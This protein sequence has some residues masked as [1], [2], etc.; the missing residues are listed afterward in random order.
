MTSRPRPITRSVRRTGLR[1][2]F[3]LTEM[4]VVIGITSVLLFLLF[5]PLSRVLD[6]TSRAEAKV[7]GQDTVRAAMRRVTRDLSN[8][9]VI[10]PPRDVTVWGFDRWVN[11]KNRPRPDTGARPEPYVLRNGVIAFRLPKHRYFCRASELN[12]GTP[13]HYVTPQD[14]DSIAPGRDP[15]FDDAIALDTCPRH[16]AAKVDLKVQQPLE[17]DERVTAYFVGLKNPMLLDTTTRLPLYQNLLAF[18]AGSGN[19]LNTYVLYRVEFDPAAPQFA[20]FGA[21]NFFYDATP[22]R[23]PVSGLTKPFSQ[24]WLESSTAIIQDDASD[25]IRW[26]ENSSTGKFVPSSVVNFATTPF[27]NDSAQPN[28]AAGQ[29]QLSGFAAATDLPA[30]DYSTQYGNWVLTGAMPTGFAAEGDLAIPDALRVSNAVSAGIVQGPHIQVFGFAV[31]KAGGA[32]VQ[33]LVFDSETPAPRKR[34]VAFDPIRGVVS[35]SLPRRRNRPLD[36]AESGEE[37]RFPGQLASM[38]RD[39]F[40]ATIDLNGFLVQL[41]DDV[42]TAGL[43]G[44]NETDVNT[45]MPVAYGSARTRQQTIETASANLEDYTSVAPG[46][47]TVTLVDTSGAILRTEPLRRAGW[48]GLGRNDHPISQGDLQEDEY[49]I[50]YRSG[51]ITLSDRRPGIW[52]S[53]GPASLGFT[54]HLMVKYEFQTNRSNDIVKVSY[55]TREL[56]TV[57]LGVVEYTKRRAEILPFE[58]SERVAIRN[59]KR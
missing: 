25:V 4:L 33:E 54:Q 56:M 59:L 42:N 14:I 23:D 24:W 35:L 15:R 39:A 21:A 48:T 49:A 6:L 1:Q 51:I 19:Y 41:G 40:S 3:T 36:G 22:V 28:R 52:T 34:L 26:V 13:D 7:S 16:P 30:T 5:I 11:P 29:V 37:A 17:P 43:E 50:D 9:M 12:T 38:Y 32:Q 2:G 47:E 45:G 58:V 27:E 8:A 20:N 10:Y 31:P 46:S 57:N 55:A 18:K 44:D 53:V